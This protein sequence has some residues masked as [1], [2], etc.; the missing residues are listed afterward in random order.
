MKRELK[1]L[2][3]YLLVMIALVVFYF[4]S[5]MTW[6]SVLWYLPVLI[7]G[8]VILSFIYVNFEYEDEEVE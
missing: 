6:Y 3:K 7:S 8:A 2:G 1:N 4:S 5:A